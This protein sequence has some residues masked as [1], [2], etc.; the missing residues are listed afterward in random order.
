MILTFLV[1]W[2]PKWDAFF[3]PE[4]RKKMLHSKYYFMTWEKFFLV[5]LTNEKGRVINKKTVFD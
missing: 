5:R 2:C 4:S 1:A 3:L